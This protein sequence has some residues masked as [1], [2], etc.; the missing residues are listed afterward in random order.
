M[1]YWVLSDSSIPI[2]HSTVQ[3]ITPEQLRTEDLKMAI[4]ALDPII[5][6]NLGDSPSD[7]SIHTYNLDNDD[8]PDTPEHITPK[9]VPME[10]EN[11]MPEADKWDV[12]AYDNYISAEVCLTKNESEV[13]GTVVRKT[14]TATPS[15]NP[16]LTQ[17]WITEN[18][19]PM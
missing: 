3:P 2:I 1:C 19:L 14:A 9:Y 8:D 7:D 12:E 4:N 6:Q 10:I 15:A 17:S 13:I 5:S 16:T 18:I 11:S